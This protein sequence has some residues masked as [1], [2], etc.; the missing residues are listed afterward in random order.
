MTHEEIIEK[1][2]CRLL[3]NEPFFGHLLSSLTILPHDN[4]PK[5]QI[6]GNV[7]S[8]NPKYIQNTDIKILTWQLVHCIMHI[9]F[10]HFT[11]KKDRN[12]QMWDLATDIAVNNI[13]YYENNRSIDG[14]FDPTFRNKAAE[15]IYES[16]KDNNGMIRNSFD[17]HIDTQNREDEE[18]ALRSLV[19][20][21]SFAKM[22]GKMPGGLELYINELLNPKLNWKELLRKFATECLLNEDYSF[23]RPRKSLLFQGIYTA[24]L[25]QETDTLKRLV[26]GIDTSGSITDKNLKDFFNEIRA[27]HHLSEK[28]CIIQCDTIIQDIY[29]VDIF[30]KIKEI[31]IKGRGGTD[32]RPVFNYVKKNSIVPSVLIYLTDL[33]GIF[34]DKDPGYPVLW[35]STD[36]SLSV[37]FGKKISIE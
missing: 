4:I 21:Q 23:I 24:S 33:Y 25:I 36:K 15:H 9:A 10:C 1:L 35:V 18:E 22:M 6:H 14:N 8:Y 29:T 30:S 5:L 32:F 2:K 37:P 11:R 31:K 3:I 7:I 17:L 28:T 13:L 27:L 12:Q 34:P 20:A 16:I 26:V 19:E